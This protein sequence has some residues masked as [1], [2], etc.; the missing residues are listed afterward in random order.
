MKGAVSSWRAKWVP[1][2]TSYGQSL[3]NKAA[4]TA[5]ADAHKAY[6]GRR[7]FRLLVNV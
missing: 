1:A 3:S 6:K 4:R 7:F 2:I 5:L